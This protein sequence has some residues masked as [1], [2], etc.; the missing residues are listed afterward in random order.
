MA[1]LKT[2]NFPMTVKGFFQ[3]KEKTSFFRFWQWQFG[4]MG[5]AAGFRLR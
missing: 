1:L 4:V 3:I 2:D 5:C